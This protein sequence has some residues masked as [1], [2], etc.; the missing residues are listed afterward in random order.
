MVQDDN[1]MTNNNKICKIIQ[2][3]YPKLNNK[4]MNDPNEQNFKSPKIIIKI[5]GMLL[6]SLIIIVSIVR[7]R[8]VN[9]EQWQVT[10][11]GTGKISYTPDIANVHLG[12]QIDKALN[13]E[14]ALADLNSKISKAMEAIKK[15]GIA[16]EDIQ[17]Q[18]YSIFPQYDY[19]EGASKFVGYNANQQLVV[20][21]KNLAK[22]ANLVSKVISEST[23]AGVNQITG[24]TFDVS[25][26]EELKQEARLVAIA[27][28][29]KK[30]QSIA[31]ALGVRLGNVVGWWE[32]SV[33][34]PG[35][36]GPY[37]LD[38]KG[39][40]GDQAAVPAGGQEIIIEVGVNYK[41]R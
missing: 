37:Y 32:N 7:D 36:P 10:V 18:N 30:A 4:N 8:I 20:K 9:R 16:E 39:G 1:I 33:Q 23:K 34:A 14:V 12:V 28:A 22:D 3:A 41:I 35:V 25:K 17:T 26:F 38:E 19:A 21:V 5:L 13:A 40:G 27:D 15:L 29:K 11:G 24:I 31:L 2:T 6:L